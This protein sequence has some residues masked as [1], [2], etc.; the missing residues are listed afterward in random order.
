ML[1][2]ASKGDLKFNK[3][4][5]RLRE[6]EVGEQISTFPMQSGAQ[7]SFPSFPFAQEVD[8]IYMQDTNMQQF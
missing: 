4:N 8:K 1:K 6:A 5:S 7:T 2:N 3:W